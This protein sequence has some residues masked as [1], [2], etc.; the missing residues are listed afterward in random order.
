M[1]HIMP[2]LPNDPIPGIVSPDVTI[3]DASSANPAFGS[4]LIIEQLMTPGEDSAVVLV[5]VPTS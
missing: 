2:D 1:K 3:A 4:D 5:G